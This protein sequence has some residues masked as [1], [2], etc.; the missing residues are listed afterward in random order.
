[1][2]RQIYI[3]IFIVLVPFYFKIFYCFPTNVLKYHSILK[4]LL[5]IMKTFFSI[6]MNID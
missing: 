2:K 3:N 1:M 6:V 5:T 4:T